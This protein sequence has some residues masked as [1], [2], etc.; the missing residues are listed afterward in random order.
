MFGIETIRR[1]EQIVAVWFLFIYTAISAMSCSGEVRFSTDSDAPHT[2]TEFVH[3]LAAAD[4]GAN[5]EEPIAITFDGTETALMLYAALARAGKYVALDLSE[6]S[7]TGFGDGDA[8][9][10][11]GLSYIVSIVL[12]NNLTRIGSKAFEGCVNLREV[13]IPNSVTEIGEYAFHACTSLTKIPIPAS[14]TYIDRDAFSQCKALVTVVLAGDTRLADNTVFP[15][16][17][18]FRAVAAQSEAFSTGTYQA[19]RGTYQHIETNWRRL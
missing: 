1:C 19:A 4:G 10:P 12:P 9:N 2:Y 15:D 8:S 3:V 6:S 11:L 17:A 13:L 7:V 14:V 5:T 16:G 18:A